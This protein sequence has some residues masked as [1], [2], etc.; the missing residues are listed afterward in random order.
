MNLQ[1]PSMHPTWPCPSGRICQ[2]DLQKY[3]N[4]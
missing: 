2:A 3:I 4:E 1:Q